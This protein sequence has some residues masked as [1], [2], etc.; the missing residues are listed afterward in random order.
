MTIQPRYSKFIPICAAILL[1]IALPAPLALSGEILD[2][3]TKLYSQF[4]EELIIR[5]FFNDMRDGF[6]LDIGCAWAE[7]SST[8]YYLEKHLGW[9][10]IGVD[11]LDSYAPGW[12]KL[13]PNSKFLAYAI[14]DVSGE[15]VTFY[16]GATPTISS[17]DKELVERWKGKEPKA[18]QV[19]TI[20]LDKLH[21][22]NGITKIDLLSM[23][24]EGHEL[25]AL[26]GFDI[27]RFKPEFACVESGRHRSKEGAQKIV[28]YFEAHGYKQVKVSGK[29]DGV[30]YY[31]KR[32]KPAKDQ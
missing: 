25:P 13:R 8:T 7:K 15:T 31:F 12:E 2:T 23:D 6:Y 17:L 3:G 32:I 27:E 18:V 11:A 24:I 28:D 30:N 14:S 1:L 20:T 22:D 5:D 10:G 29:H 19:Q 21:E 9:T 16:E 26:A 4:D